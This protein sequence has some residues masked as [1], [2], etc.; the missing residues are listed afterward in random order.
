MK[1]ISPWMIRISK[2]LALGTGAVA[3]MAVLTGCPPQ[4][5]REPAEQAPQE[6]PV[7]PP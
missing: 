5:E 3:L 2:G 4:E 1:K 6:E 7:T